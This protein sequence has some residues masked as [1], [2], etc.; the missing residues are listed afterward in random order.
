M[1]SHY[2]L[3]SKHKHLCSNN[4]VLMSW[5]KWEKW[6]SRIWEWLSGNEDK[7]NT[8]RTARTRKRQEK[9]KKSK[10][11]KRSSPS[12]TGVQLPP[13]S[14]SHVFP[15]ISMQYPSK[16]WQICGWLNIKPSSFTYPARDLSK[17][18]VDFNPTLTRWQ[19]VK[20]SSCNFSTDIT[21]SLQIHVYQ[22]TTAEGQQV[23]PE[24]LEVVRAAHWACERLNT[25][26]SCVKLTIALMFTRKLPSCLLGNWPRVSSFSWR[27]V[28][29]RQKGKHFISTWLSFCLGFFFP[30]KIL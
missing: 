10:V 15:F 3:I 26:V 28:L 5:Q 17:T 16:Q 6:V 22:S 7:D 29:S 2:P 13:V 24:Y 19:A 11:T 18:T 20:S 21:L 30:A 27:R 4:G 8:W 23:P 12:Q 25:S 9:K 14:K 1:N